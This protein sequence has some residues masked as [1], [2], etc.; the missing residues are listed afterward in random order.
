MI[1][2]GVKSKI[3]PLKESLRFNPGHKYSWPELSSLWQLRAGNVLEQE[4]WGHLQD[5]QLPTEPV[6]VMAPSLRRVRHTFH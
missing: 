5:K 6:P 1:W 4:A 2:A 3:Y